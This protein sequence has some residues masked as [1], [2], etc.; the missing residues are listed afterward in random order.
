M[1]RRQTTWIARTGAEIVVAVSVLCV[2]FGCQAGAQRPLL[3]KVADIPLPGPANR[4]DYQSLDPQAHRLYV[5]HMDNDSVVV[6]DTAAEK[7]V[8]DVPGFPRVRGVLVV[9]AVQK[10]YGCAARTHEIVVASTQS[11]A[12]IKRIPC[13][14]G[15]DGLAWSP[16]TGRLFVSDE[17]GQAEV[18]ID[19]RTDEQIGV[20]PMGGEVGNT[21]YDP[22]SHRIVACVQTR[23]ELVVIDPQSNQIVERYTLEGGQHPH[24]L[25][26]DDIHGKA[27]IACEGN[28]RLLVFDLDTR[29]VVAHFP[30]GLV[31][32]VLAFDRGLN[33]LYVAAEL[34]PVSIFRYDEAQGMLVK[35]GQISVGSN[36]HSVSVDSATHKV[37]FPLQSVNGVPTLRIMVPSRRGEF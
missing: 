21:Q 23:D 13:G 19:T 5:S 2:P 7:V 10:F 4:F 3:E 8:A 6:F 25:L 35:E 34:G 24:G 33:L 9:P 16:E 17:S 20:I 31:P 29:Q 1:E 27:Y 30:T 26:I 36:A 14:R 18:V 15:P 32:D 37:Y 11:L 22:K 28:S 12:V